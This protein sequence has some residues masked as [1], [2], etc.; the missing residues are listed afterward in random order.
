MHS[1]LSQSVFDLLTNDKHHNPRFCDF[2]VNRRKSFIER[3][4]QRNGTKEY[5][6]D[7]RPR[8]K[9]KPER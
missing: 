6:R 5:Q 3:D 8:Q 1:V 7:D 2:H 4:Q 9:S